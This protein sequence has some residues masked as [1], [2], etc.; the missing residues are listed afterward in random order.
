MS[1]ISSKRNFS[2]SE[3]ELFSNI[4]LINFPLTYKKAPL[5]AHEQSNVINFIF[6][7]NNLPLI[8]INAI[9]K[10][11]VKFIDIENNKIIYEI[12]SN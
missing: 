8:S 7:D 3:C 11:K 1:E 5:F 12:I 2:I 10:N 9:Q 6:N 4:S